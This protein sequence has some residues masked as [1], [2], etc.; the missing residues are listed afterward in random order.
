MGMGFHEVRF[1]AS[2][3]FGSVGGPERRTE[4]VALTNGFEERNTPWAQSKRRYDAGMSLRSLDE[5]GE[6]IAF[7]EARQGQLFGFRWKDWADYKSCPVSR[8]PDYTDQM[9]AT[10]DGVRTAFS[11]T[12]T[13][14]SGL[15]SWTRA[16]AK[17]VQGTVLVGLS[18]DPQDESLHYTV[19]YAT[20]LVTFAVPPAVDEAVT[21]GFEFDVPVRFDT[22]RIAVS[23]A[24]FH[25]GEVPQIPVLEVRL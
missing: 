22:D 11:L 5:I 14:A 23:V 17:P 18:G 4:I 21:A 20:G 1:P 15:S 8:E 12:K 3:S 6:V 10:G 13:Y 24:S 16:I 25:A 7:F 2:L 19:D 9:I